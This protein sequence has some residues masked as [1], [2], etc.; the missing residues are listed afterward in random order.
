M[1]AI[2]TFG[3]Y[4]RTEAAGAATH[5]RVVIPVN[6]FTADWRRYNLVSNYLAEYSAYQFAQKDRAE[7]L[8][9]SVFYELIEHVTRSSRREAMLDIRFGTADQ[10]LRFDVASSFAK[11]EAAGFKA[12]MLELG[13]QELETVYR[14]ML[15]TELEAA[16]GRRVIGL[17][18]IAHDYHAEL[19]AQLDPDT[20]AVSLRALIGEQ[21]IGS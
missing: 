13:R 5:I 1:S 14:Q 6:D 19:S 21:E 10:W 16:A 20:G 15:E 7:N 9:S 17:V 8:I 12:F 18:M 2:E 11:E 3:N 4:G